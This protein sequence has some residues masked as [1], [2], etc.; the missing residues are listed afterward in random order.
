MD[1]R[2]SA[3]LKLILTIYL[4]VNSVNNKYLKRDFLFQLQDRIGI[5]AHYPAKYI[6]SIQSKDI[7]EEMEITVYRVTFVSKY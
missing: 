4:A 7:I 2:C 6:M 5:R 1:I 3:H